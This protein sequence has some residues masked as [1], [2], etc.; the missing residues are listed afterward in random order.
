M[1]ESRLGNVSWAQRLWSKFTLNVRSRP[2]GSR[3]RDQV[4]AIMAMSTRKNTHRVLSY[5]D[6]QNVSALA[7]SMTQSSTVTRIPHR[8][9]LAI[10]TTCTLSIRTS[11]SDNMHFMY[12]IIRTN[13]IVIITIKCNTY[14]RY[15]TGLQDT[16]PCVC[17]MQIRYYWLM[18]LT[19][20]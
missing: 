7:H 19:K 12:K 2:V 17:K 20:R 9:A 6:H 5:S 16:L 15:F 18:R 14:K 13:I 1:I 8:T 4:T 3:G 11:L 10:H